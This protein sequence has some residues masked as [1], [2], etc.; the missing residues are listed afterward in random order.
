MK[1]IDDID[2]NFKVLKDIKR[3]N[4]RIYS[5]LEK[6][7]KV[8]GV[9]YENGK[10]R[11]IPERTAKSVS[12]KVYAL[13]SNTAGGR[14]M[15][16]TDSRYIAISAK[17]SGV[18]RMPHFAF[19]GSAGFDMYIRE[20]GREMFNNT[21]V[22]P[23]DCDNGFEGEFEFANSEMR[24]LVINFPLYSDVEELNIILDDNARVEEASG[25]ACDKPIVYYGS[26]ITQGGC[27]SKPGNAYE[28]II[29][30]S[31]NCDYLNLGF[32]GS[33]LAEREMAEYIADLDMRAF[34]YDYDFN[35]PTVEHLK[36]THEAMFKAIRA[37]NPDLPIIFVTAPS[38]DICLAN[39]R[40]MEVIYNTYSNAVKGGD[41]NVYFID[42]SKLL[43]ECGADG[44]VEGI[45]PNDLGFF[46]MAR[47]IGSMLNKILK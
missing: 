11:R 8:Y 44:L 1:K 27:A 21:F 41:E 4:V 28:S 36:K 25:Y 7:F 26:S 47:G 38:M 6:T 34:V 45:H 29:S 12:E 37:K 15:F 13:H 22:P 9:F 30:R 20:N 23:Y 24:E 17:M 32:S 40:R 19:T 33:A 43:E 39:G 46:F 3:E 42:G 5:S 14:I 31:L 16:K 18:C 2:K 10:Y 35:A